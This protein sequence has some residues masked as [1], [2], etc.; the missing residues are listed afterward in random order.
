MLK[1]SVWFCGKMRRISRFEAGRYSIQNIIISDHMYCTFQEMWIRGYY[2][3]TV[4][5]ILSIFPI[6]YTVPG[7]IV[8]TVR[9]EVKCSAGIPRY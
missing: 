3:V 7:Y 6:L 1:L 4:G 9:K 5:Q 2:F 8:Y